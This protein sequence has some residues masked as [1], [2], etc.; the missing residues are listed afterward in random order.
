MHE[1]DLEVSPLADA[2]LAYVLERIRSDAPLDGTAS[3]AELDDKVGPTITAEGLG[4]AEA[5]RRFVDVLAPA[6]ISQDHPRHL[7]F[8]PNAP[9]EASVLFDLVV[10][11]SSMFG[12]SWLEAAGAVY[13]ENAALRWIADLVGLPASAGGVFVSGGS[14][15]N[16]AALVA[17]RYAASQ[18]RERPA[19]WRILASNE[20]HSSIRMT[21][22]VMDV[23]IVI[24]PVDDRGRLTGTAVEQAL[25]AD[26]DK[27]IFAVVATAGTTNAG[28]VDNLDSVGEVTKRH[29]VWFH[30][31]GAYG[32]AALASNRMRHMFKGIEV[33][34]SFVVDPHKWFFAPFDCAAVLY[35][36]P[37]IA[38]SAHTQK[39]EYLEAQ[40]ERDE[41]NPSEYAYHLSRRARGLPFWFS[42]ATHGTNAYCAA[43]DSTI[44]VA[45][46]AGELIEACEY[47]ELVKP[48][49][50]SIVLLRRVGWTKDDYEAWSNDM[51]EKQLCFVVPTTWQGETVLRFCIVN[52]RTTIKDIEL[53]VESLS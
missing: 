52:P 10:S 7:S 48:V 1:F 35:R 31:D 25:A 32:G 3:F 46:S 26:T 27:S 23:D 17:A 2:V 33:C 44:D 21:A 47:T 16:L 22:S 45:L 29:N 15:G 36:D 24:V 39:A 42:L 38:R 18:G 4:G 53:I 14:A 37:A 8:V 40:T 13:A 11:A 34:D 51:L 9:T 5:L 49:G 20:A 41:W 28:I 43:V 12:G 19:R 30:V 50:L 6:T